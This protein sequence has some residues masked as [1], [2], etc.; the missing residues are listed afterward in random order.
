VAAPVTSAVVA[1]PVAGLSAAAGLAGRRAAA[2]QPQEVWP[3]VTAHPQLPQAGR[4]AA[5]HAGPPD[6]EV[7]QAQPLR[8][9]LQPPSTTQD[10]PHQVVVIAVATTL[11]WTV[12][13]A[14][15]EAQAA[16]AQSLPKVVGN[17]V[18]TAGLR[19]I[20][21]LVRISTADRADITETTTAHREVQP[22]TWVET[23]RVNSA[24][25][26]IQI[27]MARAGR[28]PAQKNCRTCTESLRGWKC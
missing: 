15:R 11:H 3:Q 19:T 28:A 6:S 14:V 25:W 22:L 4:E 12:R 24:T 16:V 5:K 8:L 18:K 10:H 7:Q 17:E 20:L 21:R 13:L 26:N 9:P 27:A 1:H 2:A 23:Y